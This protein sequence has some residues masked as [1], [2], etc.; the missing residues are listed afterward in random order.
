MKKVVLYLCAGILVLGMTACGKGGD[1]SGSEGTDQSSEVSTSP[2]ENGNGSSAAGESGTQGNGSGASAEGE[3]STEADPSG[4]VSGGQDTGSEGWSEEM[5][6][7]KQ[8][9]VE[10]LGADNYWPDMPMDAE[11]LETFY[12]ITPDMYEDYMAESPM[13]SANV[14]TLIIVK[15]KEDSADAVEEALNAYREALVND[16][17]QYPQ[18]LGK[19]QA[20]QVERIDNYVI[21]VQLGG[22][23][24]EE[25]KEEDAIAKCQ[26]ANKLAIDTISGKL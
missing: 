16:T 3:P 20:S 6:G 13:I 12:A 1:A 17:M 24:I 19:I 5:E 7:L 18:N 8:A 25:E 22:F 21:F 15:A 9:V 23:A 2:E 10:A 4:E 11:M 26:E 14:D